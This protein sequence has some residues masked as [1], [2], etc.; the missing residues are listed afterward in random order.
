MNV[1]ARAKRELTGTGRSLHPTIELNVDIGIQT[2]YRYLTIY[3]AA[4][5][6]T[7]GFVLQSQGR[8]GMAD[9]NLV[10]ALQRLT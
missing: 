4:E 2:I 10:T 6:A 9:R 7:S 5:E 1:A 3:N 8:Q